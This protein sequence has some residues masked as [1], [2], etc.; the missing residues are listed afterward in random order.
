MIRYTYP[1]KDYRNWSKGFAKILNQRIVEKKLDFHP[2]I[3]SGYIYAAAI[4]QDISYVILN[5]SFKDDLVLFR[6]KNRDFG[7]SLTFHQ[8]AVSDFFKISEQNHTH[9]RETTKMLLSL[10]LAISVGLPIQNLF[11][12][13]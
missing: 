6:K 9:H 8:V 12:G 10:L 13:P 1:L 5:C 4:N 11:F 3:G 2:S 7:L